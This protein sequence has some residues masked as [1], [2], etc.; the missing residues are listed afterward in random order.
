MESTLPTIS[1]AINFLSLNSSQ[2]RHINDNIPVKNNKYKQ[3]LK[4]SL[5][6][7][8]MVLIVTVIVVIVVITNGKSKLIMRKFEKL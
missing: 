1:S 4:I 5:L 2:N 3:I 6:I 7:A 8:T